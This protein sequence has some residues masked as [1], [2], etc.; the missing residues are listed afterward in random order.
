[1]LAALLF[2]AAMSAP[3]GGESWASQVFSLAVSYGL[4]LSLAAADGRTLLHIATATHDIALIGM[5]RKHYLA[6]GGPRE[7]GGAVALADR[8]GQSALHL[9]AGEISNVVI[10]T[11]Q[12]M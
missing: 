3:T 6:T 2:P 11:K 7:W 10:A 1:M 9:A 5:L 12:A 4:D 8:F